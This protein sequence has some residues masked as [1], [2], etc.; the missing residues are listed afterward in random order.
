MTQPT[1]LYDELI[2]G[3]GV[4]G[5]SAALH[6]AQRGRRVAVLEQFEPGHTRGS[7][8]GD[9]RIIR[10]AYAEPE[11]VEMARQAYALW[12]DL[13]QRAGVELLTLTGGWDCG[14]ADHPHL[15]ALEAN[16]RA[17]G[18]P[19]ERL[20]AAASRARFPHFALPATSQAVYQPDGGIVRASLA[21]KTL[22]VLAERAGAQLFPHTRVQAV[23]PGPAHVTIRAANGRTW[24]AGQVILAAGAWLNDLLAP[25]GL[26]LPLT[27]TQEQAAY[28]EARWNAPVS[29]RVGHMP[30]FIDHHGPR[31]NLSFYGLPQ[32][33]FPGVKVGL[34]HAGAV[35]HP[36]Q[37]AALNDE[38]LEALRAYVAERL[39]HLHTQPQWP[40]TCLYTSTPDEHFRLGRHPHAP[41]LMVASACSGHGF[42][43]GP[44]TGAVLAELALGQPTRVDIR[45]FA[46]PG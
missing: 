39:P 5:S 24:Q 2:I 15:A 21:V 16:Y 40:L 12:R 42:K 37:R 18:L 6:L 36:D 31:H 23:E 30:V 38:A 8:H 22:W 26:Q 11:Y 45:P 34:H 19:H 25:T 13:G 44:V 7:S 28:F 10:Y 17:F 29:H 33:D 32:I 1:T 27:V 35:I 9:G 14:P 41:A 43:F 20:T 4:V 46:L 3:G